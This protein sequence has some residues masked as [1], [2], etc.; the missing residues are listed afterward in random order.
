M[1][2]HSDKKDFECIVCKKT[3]K[4]AGDLRVHTKIHGPDEMRY[5]HCCELCGK[6]SVETTKARSSTVLMCVFAALFRFTQRANLEAHLRVHT[7]IKPYKCD[8]CGKEFSQKGNMDEHRRTHTGEKP[9]VC[10]LC[11]TPFIRRL[12]QWSEL[13]I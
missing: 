1:L 2:V 6:R 7:G 10:E 12:K 8:F 11:G 4:T 9:F 5:T 3:F 13:F